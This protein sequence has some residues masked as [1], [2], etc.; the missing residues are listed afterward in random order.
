MSKKEYVRPYGYCGY[1]LNFGAR[2]AAELSAKF[3]KR[4]LLR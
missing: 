3:G 4:Q 2:P 1:I